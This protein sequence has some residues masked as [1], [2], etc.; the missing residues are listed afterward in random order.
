MAC[1]ASHGAEVGTG[2]PVWSAATKVPSAFLTSM[3]SEPG[4]APAAG[5]VLWTIQSAG[6][7]NLTF[8]AGSVYVFHVALVA[9]GE[10]VP[11]PLAVPLCL[12]PPA[13]GPPA[14]DGTVVQAV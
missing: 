12:G 11:A 6:S 9:P 13:I 8:F 4:A 10:G 7:S 5:P 1:A 14:L 3:C 2:R